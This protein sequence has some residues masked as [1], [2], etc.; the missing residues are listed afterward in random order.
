MK[1]NNDSFYFQG[2]LHII[3]LFCII[4]QID[5]FIILVFLRVPEVMFN[6]IKKNSKKKDKNAKRRYRIIK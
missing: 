2:E 5:L 6:I 4:A 1:R 3:F